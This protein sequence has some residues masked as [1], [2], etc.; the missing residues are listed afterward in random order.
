MKDR[1]TPLTIPSRKGRLAIVT[2]ATSGIGK[3]TARAL[4]LAG[5]DVVL[6]VR[7][8]AKGQ[9]VA[10]DLRVEQPEGT[11]TV[12]ELDTSDLSSVAARGR[13]R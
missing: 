9:A 11:H 1:L 8:I 2:G 3:A 6:A 13:L 7:D 4:G 5:V 10:E 12:A